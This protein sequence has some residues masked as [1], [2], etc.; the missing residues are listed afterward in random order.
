MHRANA[1]KIPFG[2]QKQNGTPLDSLGIGTPA[3][4]HPERGRPQKLLTFGRIKIVSVNI[5]QANEPIQEANDADDNAN[6]SD[7]PDDASDSN[8]AAEDAANGNENGPSENGDHNGDNENDDDA[9]AKDAAASP[10]ME[11]KGIVQGE[12]DDNVVQ[13][14]GQVDRTQDF[15]SKV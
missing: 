11:I 12:A 1:H 8:Q 14:A 3:F 13:S 5:S 15:N 6:A 7:Q 2:R 4:R 9:N 10:E